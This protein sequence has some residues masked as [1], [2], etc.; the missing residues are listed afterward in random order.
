MPEYALS[1]IKKLASSG[2]GHFLE[3]KRKVEN[4]RKIVKELI[5]FSNADGGRLI[6]GISDNGNVAGL[7]HPEGD[8]FVLEKAVRKHTRGNLRLNH[9]I[10]PIS[11]SRSVIV[12]DIPQSKR[13]PNYFQEE[14]GSKKEVFI[15]AEDEC[16]RASREYGEL[17]AFKR[18]R[19]FIEYGPEEEWLL[20]YLNDHNQITLDKYR[21]FRKL[22]RRKASAILVRLAAAGILNLVP[23]YGGEDKFELA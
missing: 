14:K 8:W 2:E 16:V 18:R 5:A 17:L 7:D 3:F 10:V 4:P 21:E 9:E 1:H 23:G 15:R 20:S 12:I 13:K 19:I 22:T 6:I 11:P